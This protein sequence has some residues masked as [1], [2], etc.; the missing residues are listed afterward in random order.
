MKRIFVSG[1]VASFLLV[2]PINIPAV[3][4]GDRVTVLEYNQLEIGMKYREVQKIMGSDGELYPEAIANNPDILKAAYRWRNDD[5]SEIVAIFDFSN[6]LVRYY[7]N[8]LGG[9]NFGDNSQSPLVTSA[10]FE[11]IKA[12]MT[13]QEV[14]QIIGNGGR[15]IEENNL[16]SFSSSNNTYNWINPDGTGL[17]I[18]FDGSDRVVSTRSYNLNATDFGDTSWKRQNNSI[19]KQLYDRLKLGMT[20]QEISNIMGSQGEIDG[21]FN[22]EALQE[23]MAADDV[24]VNSTLFQ[25]GLRSREQVER[26]NQEAI[27]T[28]KAAYKWMNPDGTGVIV[29]FNTADRAVAIYSS[30]LGVGMP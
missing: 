3:F 5:G 29:V 13:Y 14:V 8:N 30:G 7:S 15:R 12:G 19:T 1:I 28:L 17:S 26:D 20:Y 27:E 21:N 10:N 9:S 22:L 16:D 24:A 18:V 11:R 6:S 2:L 25:L 4:A 23:S